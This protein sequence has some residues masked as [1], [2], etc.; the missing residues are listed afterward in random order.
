M[1]AIPVLELLQ[2]NIKEVFIVVSSW[3][4]GVDYKKILKKKSERVV[5]S[6]YRLPSKTV[7]GANIAFC[8]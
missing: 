1:K 4:M 8:G 2:S 6:T 7:F 3:G 5:C